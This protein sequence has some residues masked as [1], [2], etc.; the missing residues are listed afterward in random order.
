MG[1]ASGYTRDS[2]DVGPFTVARVAKPNLSQVGALQRQAAMTQDLARKQELLY[3]A[4]I[5]ERFARRAAQAQQG[6]QDA[7]LGPGGDPIM[8]SAYQSAAKMRRGMMR[9]LAAQEYNSALPP[10][11]TG[12][13]KGV[14]NPFYGA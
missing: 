1:V 8:G 6:V 2:R 3:L 13:I 11:Y 7:T 10:G 4:A 9:D 14:G 5:E 12:P